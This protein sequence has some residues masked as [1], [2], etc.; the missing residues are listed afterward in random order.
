MLTNRFRIADHNHPFEKVLIHDGEVPFGQI[1]N[2]SIDNQS[3]NNQLIDN[4][5]INNQSIDNQLQK[6]N[7]T[8]Q[9]VSFIKRLYNGFLGYINFFKDYFYF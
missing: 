1:D 9:Q 3:I 2:Q 7:I 5:S 4:Q 6:S 8:P